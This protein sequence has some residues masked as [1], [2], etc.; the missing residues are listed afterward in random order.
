MADRRYTVEVLDINLV[1]LGRIV[2]FPKLDNSLNFLEFSQKLSDYGMCRF[3]VATEDEIFTHLSNLFTPYKHHIRVRRNGVVV[4]QGIVVNVPHRTAK[5]LEVQAYEYA[6]L[7]KKTLVQHDTVGDTNY[8]TL[9]SGTMADAI[10]TFITETS[11][12][13]GVQTALA[14]L[15][16]GT[17]ENPNFPDGYVDSSNNSIAGQPWTF[18]ED[19]QLKFDYRDMLYVISVL[20]AYAQFDFEITTVV[21]DAGVTTLTFDFKQYIG[22][23]D[24]M[25]TFEYGPG[26]AIENFDS[27]LDGEGMV[28]T[29]TGIAADNDF[30]ILAIRDLP[31]ASSIDTYGTLQGVAA[32]GDAKNLNVLR[33]R[34]N[35][36]LIVAGIPDV[37]IRV[38]LSDRAM[39]LGKYHI[40]DK[41]RFIIN[42]NDIQVD[43][44]RRI[45][46]IDVKVNEN[47]HETINLITNVP[48]DSQL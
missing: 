22:N 6:F 7:L 10:T 41:A 25:H 43:Q 27:P 39:P 37:E 44:I 40:G 24:V 14:G 3:R 45:I 29:I 46:G 31:L 30:N 35:E 16:I 9:K 1:P 19:F 5:Y 13:T 4:W 32:Y 33:S 8:R 2:S 42:K 11:A 20:A 21:D 26:A 17:I 12:K 38:I 34:V 36:E 47:G 18:S 15:L 28:N 48:R 23:R